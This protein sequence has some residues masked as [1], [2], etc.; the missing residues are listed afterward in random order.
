MRGLGT[1]AVLALVAAAFVVLL[2]L[3]LWQLDRNQQKRDFTSESEAAIAA[4]PLAADAAAA[5]DE[6]NAW[7]RLA[8]EGEWDY[9]RAQIVANRTRFGLRG[10]EVHVPLL[11]PGGGPAIL[12]NRGWYPRELREQVLAELATNEPAEGLILA[13]FGTA[14]RRTADGTWTRFDLDAIAAELPYALAPIRVLAGELVESQPRRMPEELPVT[15][16][17]SFRNTTPHIEYALSWFGLA[18]ALVATAG[19]RIWQRRHGEEA[20]TRAPV[21]ERSAH[22]GHEAA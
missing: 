14:G 2:G 6:G 5:G 10:E 18:A 22:D 13:P 15:G 16:F 12:V 3:G 4:P 20:G 21:L 11:P 8:L 9:E 17:E 7:R 19:V 1:L